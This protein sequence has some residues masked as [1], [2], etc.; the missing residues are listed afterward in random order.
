MPSP[1]PID[2]I[3]AGDACCCARMAE[4]SGANL[5]GGF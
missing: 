5:A 1:T 4:A 3:S 2:F